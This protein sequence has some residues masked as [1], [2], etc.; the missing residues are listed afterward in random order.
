M[1]GYSVYP[2]LIFNEPQ[3]RALGERGKLFVS[4]GIGG[5]HANCVGAFLLPD[6]YIGDAFGWSAETVSETV[7]EALC[8]GYVNRFADGRHMVIPRHWEWNSIANPNVMKAALKVL[9]DL[10]PDPAL[11]PIFEGLER[12]SKQFKT[13]FEDELKTARERLLEQFR[14]T[15]SSSSSSSSPSSARGMEQ[16]GCDPDE[17]EIFFAAFPNPVAKHVAREEWTKALNLAPAAVI[18]AA[19]KGY[20]SLQ[21]GKDSRY[22]K[23]PATWLK[24]R[25]WEDADPAPPALSPEEIEANLDRA[26]KL[27]RR[28]KYAEQY[29]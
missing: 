1:A 12:F 20:A 4:F 2:R 13:D 27:L 15:T 8:A 10:P 24:E 6:A 21:Q 25:R 18:I 29:Q 11:S 28:G 14:N 3:F 22:V 23:H 5:P 26:D 7:Q 16:Q 19:A 9:R 17:F